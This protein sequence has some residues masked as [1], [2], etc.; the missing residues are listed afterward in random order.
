MMS[1]A[2]EF[3]VMSHLLQTSQ[4]MFLSNNVV[5][6]HWQ[7]HKTLPQVYSRM[8]FPG[9]HRFID[10]IFKHIPRDMFVALVFISR[11]GGVGLG[12][13]CCPCQVA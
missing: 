6:G 8:S 1:V 3:I 4:K 13:N 9:C 5:G 10:C 2:L 11:M 12:L 7:D